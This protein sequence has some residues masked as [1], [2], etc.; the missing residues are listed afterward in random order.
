[1][2]D[3]GLLPL[4][5][6]LVFILILSFTCGMILLQ[7]WAVE[8][9]P[10]IRHAPGW[11][12]HQV[13]IAFSQALPPSVILSAFLLFIRLKRKP[14]N[15]LFSFLLLFLSTFAILVLGTSFIGRF[16]PSSTINDNKPQHPYL[17]RSFHAD[18]SSILY[19][20]EVLY[21]QEYDTRLNQIIFGSIYEEP[22]NLI[23]EYYQNGYLNGNLELELPKNNIVAVERQS[24]I[25]GLNLSAPDFFQYA[26]EEIAIL[27][28]YLMSRYG[29]S[30]ERLIFV[31][32]A[33]SL[34]TTSCGIFSRISP[35]PLF[36]TLISLAMLRFI[37]FIFR[38]IDSDIFDELIQILPDEQIVSDLPTILLALLG[39]VFV[40]CDFLFIPYYADKKG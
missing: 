10:Q 21:S 29:N 37:F 38:L 13:P 30:L 4:I 1:V 32:L 16:Q 12:A 35:W 14:G 17:S 40:I 18:G 26:L 25:S 36:N 23:F 19:V 24:A 20:E 15:R 39:A 34:C 33:L 11:F 7:S 31:A 8:Y 3:S 28:E 5:Y 2:K 9:N 22:A 27:N 6:I